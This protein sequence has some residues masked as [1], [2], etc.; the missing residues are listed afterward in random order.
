MTRP[1]LDL[2]VCVKLSLSRS[3]FIFVSDP[4]FVLFNF[5]FCCSYSLNVMCVTVKL[6][7]F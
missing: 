4:N 6:N 7:K 3:V 5:I 1:V 2:C